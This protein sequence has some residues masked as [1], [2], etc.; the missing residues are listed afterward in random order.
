[1]TQQ[2]RYQQENHPYI[3]HPITRMQNSQYFQSNGRIYYLK[4]AT[5]IVKNEVFVN[6][7]PPL[8]PLQTKN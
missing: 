2:P 1:M 5:N 4:P 7:S 8:L 3:R 6:D